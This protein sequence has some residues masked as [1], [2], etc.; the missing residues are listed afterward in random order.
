VVV[1]T[2]ET[3]TAALAS[4]LAEV[5]RQAFP[6]Y[7][8]TRLGL[9]YC[10]RMF[11]CFTTTPR[12]FVLA[13]FSGTELSGY[14]VGAERSLLRRIDRK[15]RPRALWAAMTHLGAVVDRTLLASVIARVR[16]RARSAA[17]PAAASPPA[18]APGRTLLLHLVGTTA[19]ARGQGVGRALLAAFE[20]EALV[21]GYQHATLSVAADN[22]AA[23]R[24]YELAG[25][26]LVSTSV[27]AAGRKGC[28][29]D[30]VMET[31]RP[32]R[33]A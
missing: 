4:R 16:R 8:S 14:C 12:V 19:A 11:A 26:T 1:V 15:L 23:R 2:I 22:R 7:L 25:W 10:E 20:R 13:A 21:R 29:Y 5:H 24:A 27:D 28:R 31:A 17:R 32:I 9:G 30:R 18:P 33:P 3:A 6:R